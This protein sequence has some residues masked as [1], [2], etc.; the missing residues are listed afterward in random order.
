[1]FFPFFR[2]YLFNWWHF[3][4]FLIRVLLWFF[5]FRLILA[6]HYYIIINQLILYFILLY[7]IL[8]II[9]L[10][11]LIIIRIWRNN[12]ILDIIWINLIFLVFWMHFNIFLIRFISIHFFTIFTALTHAEISAWYS[13]LEAFTVFLLTTTLLTVAAFHVESSLAIIL[14]NILLFNFHLSLNLWL[15]SI[16]ISLKNA[17]NCL[18]SLFFLLFFIIDRITTILAITF[19]TASISKCKAITIKF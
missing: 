19:W 5:S 3:Y 12:W 13:T 18:F 4:I 14:I 7:S 1:M 9:Y 10:K 2:L 15:K 16:W 6:C 11:I 8:F 17:F